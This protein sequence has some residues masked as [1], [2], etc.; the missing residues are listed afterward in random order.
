VVDFLE[1]DVRELI[2][3]VADILLILEVALEVSNQFL[4]NIRQRGVVH[5]LASGEGE[6]GERRGEMRD[7]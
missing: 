7:T 6:G 5:R 1:L 4:Q 2:V 3:L